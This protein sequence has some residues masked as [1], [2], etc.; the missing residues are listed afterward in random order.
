MLIP[1][2]WW[3][4]IWL[5]VIVISAV[6]EF[7][8]ASLV[9][10]WVTGGALVGLVL[11]LFNVDPVIQII[12]VLVISLVCM[13]TLRKIVF[14]RFTKNQKEQNVGL[15]F[16]NGKKLTLLTPV[17]K[18]ELGTAK[19]NGVVW[20]IATQNGEEIEAGEVVKPVSIQGNVI[21]VIK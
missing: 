21:T 13:F 15:E 11:S 17:T 6:I 19:I 16:L 2:E 3:P 14:N 10:I 12:V 9:S 4:Y 20:Q 18:T 8:T 7:S 5:G 1:L